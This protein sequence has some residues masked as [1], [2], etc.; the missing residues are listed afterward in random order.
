MLLTHLAAFFI[1]FWIEL[2]I[3]IKLVLCLLVLI[4][5]VY[6]FRRVVLRIADSAITTIALD[7]DNN[8][9]LIFRNG[10]QSR[11]TRFQSIFVNPVV[12][13]LAVT[14]EDKHFPQNLVIPFDAIEAEEFRRLRVRLKR[15]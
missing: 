2:A 8:M 6:V 7:S 12:T 10:R 4:S 14:V 1:F 5:L 3:G 13:L 15:F 9:K 11:V